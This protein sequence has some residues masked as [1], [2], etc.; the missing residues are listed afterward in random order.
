MPSRWPGKRSSRSRGTE[1]RTF[2]TATDGRACGQWRAVGAVL[3][4]D[5]RMDWFY[6]VA[7]LQRRLVERFG[8]L[9]HLNRLT[10]ACRRRYRTGCVS[11][12]SWAAPATGRSIRLQE[13]AL[14]ALR[15]DLA[16]PLPL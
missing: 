11:P 14:R 2:R 5:A 16:A 7:D 8:L 13:G 15:T 12:V 1:E 4:S 6:E 9:M 3:R 10:S